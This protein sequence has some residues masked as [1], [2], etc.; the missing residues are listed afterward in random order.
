MAC[1]AFNGDPSRSCGTVTSGGT[2][3]IVLA[4]KAYRDWARNEK[5]IQDPNIVSY[6]MLEAFYT[7]VC[8]IFP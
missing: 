3:S 6:G 2:E 5:G 7:N 4:V 8:Y 1:D